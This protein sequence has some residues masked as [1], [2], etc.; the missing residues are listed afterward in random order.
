MIGIQKFWQMER[1][2]HNK[3]WSTL[4]INILQLAFLSELRLAGMVSA[5]S[6]PFDL[7]LGFH[8]LGLLHFGW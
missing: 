5:E 4:Q 8:F 2:A 1:L 7:R 6:F 3:D